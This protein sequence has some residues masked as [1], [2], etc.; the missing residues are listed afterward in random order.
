M[1]WP[2]LVVLLLGAFMAILDA[3]VVNVA[4]PSI[5]HRLHASPAAIQLVVAG[6]Q[7][8]YATA[9]VAGS[10]LGDLHGRRRLFIVGMAVFAAGSLGCGLAP[11]STALVA[12]RLVQ[13]LGAAAMFP[14]VLSLLRSVIPTSRQPLAFGALGV[15]LGSAAVVGQVLGG[16]LV[17]ANIA[18][19]AWRSVFLINLPVGLATIVAA[20]RPVPE[21]RVPDAQRPDL[22]GS[23][24][25]GAARRCLLRL[26]DPGYLV[27]ALTLQD[28]LGLKTVTAGFTYALIRIT[29][30]PHCRSPKSRSLPGGVGGLD[31]SL[32]G[33][34]AVTSWS[35]SSCMAIG[36]S[37]AGQHPPMPMRRMKIEHV[38]HLCSPR[39]R[40]PQLSH[41]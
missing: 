26:S 35:T 23:G 32:R 21:S 36:A 28:G 15:V 38:S 4:L 5:Q 18:G 25:L 33:C 30:I 24:L 1:P 22:V 34:Q 17:S 11:T 7:L 20:R 10:R 16:W 41:S 39:A 9:L 2:C 40:S 37:Q 19:L 12:F 29:E 6:Y 31:W 8:A 14:Q 27:L 13:G 3:F